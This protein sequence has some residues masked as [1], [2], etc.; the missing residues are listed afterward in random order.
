MSAVRKTTRNKQILK[1]HPGQAEVARHKARFKVVTAGR[2]WGKS[3]LSCV[4]LITNAAKKSNQ[5]VWYIAPSY[6]MC[7]QIQWTVLKNMVPRPWVSKI[8]ESELKV[9]LINGSVIQ[10]KGADNPDSLRG[11]SL[12]FVVLDE[13]QDMAMEVWQEAIR[14]T[15][16]DS[17][18]N[19]LI[20]G[21]P[22]SFN[23]LYQLHIKGISKHPH[24]RDWMSW[25]FPTITS[26]FIP[27]MEIEAARRDMNPKAFMQEFLA[28]FQGMSGRVYYCFDRKKHLGDY[29]FNPQL[30]IWVG[31]DFN[32]DP[33]SAAIMQ[34]QDN[35]EVWV[36]DE[37]DFPNSNV[38]E[39]IEELDKRY[40][41]WKSNITVFPDP[42]GTQRQHNRGESAL[43]MYREAGFNKILH[44][45]KAPPVQ[46]R[47]NAVNRILMSADGTVNM[48]INKKCRS[49]INSLEQ[50]QYKEG[51]GE[52]N[53]AASVEHL[54]D[55]M[56]YCIS[57]VYPSKKLKLLGTNL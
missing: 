33:M 16:A 3:R 32:I 46:D 36:V 13:F 40:W 25:Q 43:D 7:K 20:I 54:A 45:K 50:T 18:G 56:G 29:P 57:Y 17:G 19:A 44:K 1:L 15:L 52:V 8:H 37:I 14:P 28:S 39:V 55:A 10:L 41:R 11:V 4:E 48:R 2:R 30:P 26:P 5:V 35:G 9:T 42:A 49:L 53:K 22:K 24:D 51:T 34:R 21:T 23:G 27:A 38:Q 12:A 6:A 31:V 47:V